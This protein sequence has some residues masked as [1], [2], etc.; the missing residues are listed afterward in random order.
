MGLAPYTGAH[1]G[2]PPPAF[3]QSIPGRPRTDQPPGPTANSST[4]NSPVT[5]RRPDD[6]PHRP[7][8]RAALLALVGAASIAAAAGLL[9]AWLNPDRLAQTRAVHLLA[10]LGLFVLPSATLAFDTI[11][12]RRR[13]R[14]V[15][16]AAPDETHLATRPASRRR[17][18]RRRHAPSQSGPP[19]GAPSP[20]H[21]HQHRRRARVRGG[22]PQTL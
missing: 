11:D 19:K 16:S 20:A 2:R 10:L 7:R 5:T 1:Y 13:A 15:P 21:A 14:A 12:R 17:L 3:N 9:W 4:V 22:P 6:F 8:L 18:K